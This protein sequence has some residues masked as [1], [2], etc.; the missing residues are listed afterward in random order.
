M[1][2][3]SAVKQFRDAAAD[4]RLL[5]KP[6]MVHARARDAE[7]LRDA[8]MGFRR[9]ICVACHGIED[10]SLG[11][12]ISIMPSSSVYQDMESVRV[13][14]ESGLRFGRFRLNQKKSQELASTVKAIF[15]CSGINLFGA[16]LHSAG[17][18]SS[19]LIYRLK[20]RTL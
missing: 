13:Y 4:S 1:I 14:I 12:A 9:R 16:S 2:G 10:H 18:S 8:I 20:T 6:L 5:L 3:E 7:E 11:E 19:G 15:F 17:I